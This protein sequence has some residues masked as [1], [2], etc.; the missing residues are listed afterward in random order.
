MI[1]WLSFAVM[2]AIVIA[3]LVRPMLA[4][5][6]A[7]SA[8][9]QEADLAVYRDQIAEIEA[10]R[11]RG[12]IDAAEAESARTELARR[13]LVRSERHDD[14]DIAPTATSGLNP[15]TVAYSAA[16]TIPLLTIAIY[17]SLGSPSMPGMPQSARL[18]SAPSQASV[19]ELVAKV[20]AQ[21]RKTPEDGRG[22]DAIAP[23]YLRMQRFDDASNAFA[24]A[25]RLLGE[26]PN[27]LKGFA[28]ST[29]LANNGIVVEPA[30]QAYQRVLAENPGDRESRFWIAMAAE[31][32]GKLDVAEEG[33]RA[34]LAGAPEDAPWKPVVDARL[35]AIADRNGGSAARQGQ[36]QS[37][38][39]EASGGE[40]ADSQKTAAGATP[41]VDGTAKNPPGP[42][43]ED[44]AAASELSQG[45]QQA[46]IN[47]MVER[48]ASKLEKNP[49][50]FEGWLRLVRAYSVL[51]R[52]EDAGR[53]LI[54]A[55]K[56]AD[57]DSQKNA[58]LDALASELELG[59]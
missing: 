29:V 50:D 20:E 39:G 45:D 5:Q 56:S 17:L 42:T 52:K 28:E 27:R 35:A 34:V 43:A 12:L 58:R 1:L 6:S 24:Q 57:G 3:A 59:T 53:A 38:P 23:V 25:I 9:A 15:S 30:R 18:Q 36:D 41:A 7:N 14:D 31:Q 19:D 48:L 51:G 11:E 2:A 33:Y 8:S 47:S 46:F 40:V 49:N 32:D 54:S 10:D 21:L 26:T 55:R 44:I 16:L 37:P 22:W 4:E 13:L